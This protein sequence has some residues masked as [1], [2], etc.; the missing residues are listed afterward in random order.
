MFDTMPE[1]LAEA[2]KWRYAVKAMDASKPVSE[3]DVT[4]I[5]DAV[6][7]APTSSGTQP[8][9]VFVVTN[10]ALREKLRAVSWDQQQVT[11]CSHLLVFAAWDNYNDERI[12]AVVDQ[13]ADERPGTRQMLED[14]Y[15]N[16]KGMYLPRDPQVNFEH[17]ARNAYIA[18]GFA[19]LAAAQIKVDST[20]MEGFD[21]EAVDEIMGLKEQG[22]KSICF[23]ALGTRD[24]ANDW[25]LPMAKVRKPK[26][27]LFERID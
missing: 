8:F 13:H 24:A 17:A 26:E 18:I 21:P 16:L 4:A 2:L 11:G 23:L 12:D 22:L 25:L 15:T 3:D 19:M 7:A 20:P 14:Y 9:K 27:T 6:Q 5:L 10:D 1:T